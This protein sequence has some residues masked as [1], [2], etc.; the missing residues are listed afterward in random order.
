MSE[1]AKQRKKEKLQQP[2]KRM[3]KEK[4]I[5]NTMEMKAQH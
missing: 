3:G 4:I 2:L 1:Q 5:I